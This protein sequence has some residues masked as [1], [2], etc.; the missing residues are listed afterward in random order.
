[1][2]LRERLKD[3]NDVDGAMFEL[4]VILGIMPAGDESWIKNKGIF[5]S[6][7]PLGTTLYEMLQGLVKAGVLEFRDEPDQQFR[8]KTSNG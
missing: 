1:M 5:W 4:A 8:W 7:N 6:N 2:T 3:W